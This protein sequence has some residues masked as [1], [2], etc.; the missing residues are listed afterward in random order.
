MVKVYRLEHRSQRSNSPVRNRKNSIQGKTQEKW[1]SCLSA[2][3]MKVGV[4]LQGP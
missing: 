4:N 1:G 3:I 2:K